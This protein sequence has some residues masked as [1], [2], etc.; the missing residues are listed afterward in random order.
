MRTAKRIL[1]EFMT[2]VMV[3]QACSPTVAAVAAGWQNISS[4]IAAASAEASDAVESGGTNGDAANGSGAS[5]AGVT[6]DGAQDGAAKGD[7]ATGGDVDSVAGSDSTGDQ[8]EGDDTA[9]DDTEHDADTMAN[10]DA[11]TLAGATITDL[12]KLVELLEKNGAE[13]IVRKDGES[14]IKS[15][16][17]TR[18][19]RS[20]SCLT[21]TPRF[22]MM[23]RSRLSSRAMRSSP[24]RLITVCLSRVLA[25]M[26]VRLKAGSI[27]R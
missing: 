22:T 26:S 27:G 5:D 25:V 12:N 18:R 11:E 24:S 7:A 19:R 17:V 20:P 21:P 13:S 9:A 3:L 14:G 6:G 10:E 4:E 8:T 2:V 1:A 15:L 23:R 16:D